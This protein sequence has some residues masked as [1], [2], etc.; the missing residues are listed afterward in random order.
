MAVYS[1]FNQGIQPL[2]F[3]KPK[4]FVSYHHANDQW[5]Y[6]KFSSLF[7]DRYDVLND[8]SLDRKIDSDDAEY[9]IRRIRE[10]Y[11]TGTSITIV[12]CGKETFK[13]K[14]IDWEICATLN[15][16]HAL[17]GINLPDNPV[18]VNG[19]YIVPDRLHDN[20]QSGYAR[21][22]LW[23][24]DPQT[25]AQAISNALNS[26]KHLIDNSRETLQRNRS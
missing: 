23:S 4:V 10:E 12:L 22:M 17:L 14:F 8:S 16:E 3:V 19:T 24:D 18:T 5:D 2:Q 15:K 11:I 21:W 7:S 26:Q 9:Q 6:D 1:I 13:R 20:I 25:V